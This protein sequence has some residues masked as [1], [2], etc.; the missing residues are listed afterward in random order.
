MQLVHKNSFELLCRK[1]DSQGDYS[2]GTSHGGLIGEEMW[3]TN[4]TDLCEDRWERY[5]TYKYAYVYRVSLKDEAKLEDGVALA[6][7]KPR[8]WLQLP[9]F[10][11]REVSPSKMKRVSLRLDLV[12]PEGGELDL[13][14]V[15]EKMRTEGGQEAYKDSKVAGY[16]VRVDLPIDE[17]M[18]NTTDDKIVMDFVSCDRFPQAAGLQ[19]MVTNALIRAVTCEKEPRVRGMRLSI[20]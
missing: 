3:M 15:V 11:A 8:A 6:Q 10:T 14:N 18:A 20:R 19:P 4:C 12:A 9:K 2:F 17:L 5:T 1:H 13:D 16:N 7:P